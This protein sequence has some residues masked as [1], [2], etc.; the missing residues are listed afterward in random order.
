MYDLRAALQVRSHMTAGCRDP[1]STVV[2]DDP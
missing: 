2:N 1:S